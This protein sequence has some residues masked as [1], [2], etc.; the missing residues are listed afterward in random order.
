MFISSYANVNWFFA[1]KKL[2][3]NIKK[4]NIIFCIDEI[5]EIVSSFQN[6]NNI[7]ESDSNVSN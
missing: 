6:N 4:K 3:N 2:F 5:D 1:K 7:I